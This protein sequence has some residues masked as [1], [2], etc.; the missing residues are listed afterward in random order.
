MG[1]RNE[2][3]KNRGDSEERIKKINERKKKKN[4]KKNLERR[5]TERQFRGYVVN[6]NYD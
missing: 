4:Q 5:K 1:Q 2:S 6:R 3:C